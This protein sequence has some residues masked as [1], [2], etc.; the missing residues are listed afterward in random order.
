MFS[1]LL[2]RL[3]ALFRRK[4]VEAEMDE[5]LRAHLEQQV[6]KYVS[7]GMRREEARR[8]ARLEFG[9][10]N[11]V[12]EECRDARGVNFIETTLQDVR[13]GLRQLRRN[14]GFTAVAVITLALGIGATTAIFTVFNAV[15]LRPLPYA[16]PNE[17][18]YVEGKLGAAGDLNPFTYSGEYMAWRDQS[19]TLSTVAAYM[20]SW[21]NLTGRGEA[22][23]LT[24]GLASASFF[25]LLAVRPVVGRIFLP[26]EDRPGAPIVTILSHDLWESR[27]GGDPSIVGQ[28]VTLDGKSY[29][30]VGV[31]PAS[32]VVPDRSSSNYALW[33]PLA[34]AEAGS[35]E[36]HI[37]RV[38][39]RLKPGVSLAAAQSELNIIMQRILPKGFKHSAVL[40]RWHEEIVQGARRSLLLF[41][42]AVGSLLL[43]ACVNIANLLLARAEHRQKEMAVRLAVGAGKRRI[44]RQ[45]LT[46]SALLAVLGGIVGLALAFAGKGLLIA[47][48]SRNLPS[49][50]P[51][52]FDPR[53][54]GF[55]LVLAVLT[56]LAFGIVPALQASRISLNETL[57]EASRGTAEFLSAR[58]FRNLLAICETALALIILVGAGLL[59][60]SFLRARGIDH[61][62][63]S[64]N[65]LSVTIDLTKSKYPTPE[66]QARY[67]QQAVERIRGIEG[68]QS[69]GGSGTPPLGNRTNSE[70]NLAVEGR[71]EKIPLAF[72]DEITPDYFRA[73]GIPLLA[74]RYFSDSDREGSPS[75]AIV[76]E[77]FAR[78]YFPNGR[79]LGSRIENWLHKNDWL[80]IVGVVGDVRGSVY[81]ETGPQIYL[82][83]LQSG[84]PYITLL[85][86]TAGNPRRWEGAVRSQLASLDKD[87][88][89]HDLTTLELLETNSLTSWRVN[90]LLL[91]TFA[92]LGLILASVGMYGVMSY[93]ARHRTHEIG[94]RMALGAQKSDVLKMVVGQ[95]LKLTI[96]GVAI[97]IA[98]A[99]G[100]TR[101]LSSLLYDVKPTDPLTFV[102]VSLLLTVVALLACYIPARRAAKVDPM[103]ALRYE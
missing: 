44:V 84:E 43:I 34:D 35:Q 56:G 52:S 13:Y 24:M 59:F 23:R 31:L 88:P 20:F 91:A 27:F 71:S 49:L 63:R 61:G 14:P 89:P 39:G 1:D 77:S 37:V 96:V 2:Y 21:A 10:M 51:I 75:V 9:G 18:V 62:F 55:A 68:V 60:K 41:L 81:C 5:E 45:L 74:G 46:E 90:M 57:K 79:C 11:Q 26:E 58:L 53:V 40:L 99:F 17:L 47:L 22:E 36:A 33:V 73:M 100:L 3:R 82:P 102:A 76:N 98:G 103:V 85:V 64:E 25:R 101:F 19:R 16:H 94:I 54:L 93:S 95:G 97:G 42:G 80:T 7:S 92:A 87:Q 78:R 4:S 67:F 38:V 29:T 28:G 48:I 15:L 8:R 72:S 65:I 69:V 83:Y 66:V 70:S 12:K 32:F 86:H 50:E 30:V 6:E